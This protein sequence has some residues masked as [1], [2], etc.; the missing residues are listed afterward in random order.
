[1]VFSSIHR[2]FI[3]NRKVFRADG[4]FCVGFPFGGAAIFRMICLGILF[5]VSI[6]TVC[7]VAFISGLRYA[8]WYGKSEA[9]ELNLSKELSLIPVSNANGPLAERWIFS[10][11]TQIGVCIVRTCA[12]NDP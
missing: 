1:M 6:E 10:S 3:Y 5:F 7:I 12:D 11:Q 9:G 2:P 4:G 8:E